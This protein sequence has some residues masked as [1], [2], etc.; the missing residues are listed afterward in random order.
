[1]N[2]EGAH[3]SRAPTVEGVHANGLGRWKDAEIRASCRVGARA[4]HGVAPRS[5]DRDSINELVRAA[6]VSTAARD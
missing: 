3:P 5:G 4:M 1:M 2:G 6:A